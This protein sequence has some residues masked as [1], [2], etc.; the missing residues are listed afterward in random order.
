MRI[1]EIS[2][3]LYVDRKFGNASSHSSEEAALT[4]E[5]TATG[6]HIC[7]QIETIFEGFTIIYLFVCVGVATT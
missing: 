2:N 3:V 6:G 5:K 7:Q 1:M 4:G